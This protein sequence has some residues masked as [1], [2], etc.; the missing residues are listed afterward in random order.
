M[1]RFHRLIVVCLAFT[2]FCELADLNEF[3]YAAPGIIKFLHITVNDV[4]AITSAGFFGMF[5]GAALGGWIADLFGRRRG[6]IW[7]VIWFSIFSIINALAYN[8]PTLLIARFL[9]GIGM[10]SLTVIGITY[11]AELMPKDRRGRLQAATLAIGSLGVPIIAGVAL[12]VIPLGPEG[13][14]FVFVFGGSWFYTCSAGV[15]PLVA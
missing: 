10:S 7:S 12:L 3:A 2:F 9:T 14:R 13:W 8:V 1:G 15:A 5:I 4:A 6:L 11:L